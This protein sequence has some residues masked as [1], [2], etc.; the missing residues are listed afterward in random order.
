ME[1]VLSSGRMRR[2]P[3]VISAASRRFVAAS[4]GERVVG[5]A[6][7]DCMHCL[8]QDGL[9]GMSGTNFERG[10]ALPGCS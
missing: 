7:S 8:P 6:P 3:G 2:R 4:W 1:W 9:S 5:D 10:P